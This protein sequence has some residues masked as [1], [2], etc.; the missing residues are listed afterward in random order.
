MAR[1]IAGTRIFTGRRK[2]VCNL[3]VDNPFNTPKDVLNELSRIF[4]VHMENVSD[5]HYLDRYHRGEHHNILHR[6]KDI[7]PEVNNKVVIN[8]AGSATR[9][10]VAYFLGKSIQYVPK[11]AVNRES[12]K[13]LNDALASENKNRVDMEIA[14]WLSICGIGYRGV[15]TDKDKRNGYGFNMI[16]HSPLNTAVVHSANPTKGAAYA[17]TYYAVPSD[18]A[19]PATINVETKYVFT[20]W[21]KAK[22]YEVTIDGGIESISG[23]SSGISIDFNSKSVRVKTTEYSFGGYLPIIEYVNNQWRMGDW[24][25]SIPLMDAI[26]LSASDALNEIEQYVSSLMVVLGAEMTQE[27]MDKVAELKL[28]NI[29]DIPEGRDVTVDYLTNSLDSQSTQVLRDYLESSLRVVVG[30]P[31]RKTRSGGG[32][33]TGDAVFMRDGWQDIDLVA[34]YKEQFFIDGD[35]DSLGAVL[36]IL[37]LDKELPRNISVSDVNI[38]FNRTKTA[39]LM[40]KAQSFQILVAAGIDPIDALDMVDI[41]TDVLDVIQRSKEYK[42][43]QMKLATTLMQNNESNNGGILKTDNDST[44][45]NQ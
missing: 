28:I 4:P 30:I 37:N 36:Y 12:T 2:L 23:E 9:D 42:A 34:S 19:S 31:D 33:D 26:D 38:K 3:D 35:R 32:S 15:Y 44:N 6:T 5:I 24:E 1:I 16:S 7:R 13:V 18:T 17:F 20:V 8:Y 43:E 39:N 29:T 27:T 10:I 11:D 14:N 45:L 40:T 21:T 25:S 22:R 41:T